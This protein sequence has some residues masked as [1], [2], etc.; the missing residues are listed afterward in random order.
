VNFLL[1]LFYS[2]VEMRILIPFL[3]LLITEI[4]AQ[5]DVGH[6]IVPQPEQ[7]ARNFTNSILWRVGD[8]ENIRWTTT[9][10]SFTIALWQQDLVSSNG[11][12]GPTIFGK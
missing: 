6:F 2:L 11:T 1:K 8:K 9:Y 3:V 5:Q 12:E 4:A 10:L 7:G